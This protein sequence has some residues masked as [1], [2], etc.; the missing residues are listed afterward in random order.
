MSYYNLTKFS[1]IIQFKEN[2]RTG[3]I[4]NMMVIIQQIEQK[5]R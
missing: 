2:W 3:Y 4:L 1:D 5:N